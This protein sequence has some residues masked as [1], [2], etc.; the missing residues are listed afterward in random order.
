MAKPQVFGSLAP[1]FLVPRF[2]VPKLCLGTQVPE[3]LF[4]RD[5]KVRQ[6][7]KVRAR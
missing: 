2:L 6:R 7:S 5:K 1:D 3:T 4:R